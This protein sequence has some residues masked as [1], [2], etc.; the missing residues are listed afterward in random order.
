ML[1]GRYRLFR[2]CRFQADCLQI[3]ILHLYGGSAMNKAQH[4]CNRITFVGGTV[5]IFGILYMLVFC[6]FGVK[7]AW[8]SIIS[9]PLIVVLHCMNL[10]NIYRT[11][12]TPEFLFV[13]IKAFQKF[14]ST[15]QRGFTLYR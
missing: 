9:H 1:T 6:V 2:F 14:C 15:F 5:W 13:I 7:V 12:Y 11:P 3:L 10:W 8:A 4:L